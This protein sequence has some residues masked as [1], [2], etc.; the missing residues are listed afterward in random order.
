MHTNKKGQGETIKW[1]RN[2]A[3][4]PDP[5]CL[6]WPFYRN[7]NGYGQMGHNGESHWAHR[8]MCEL[9]HGSAPSPDHEAAHRCGSGHL[10]CVNPRHLAWR[11]KAENRQESTLHGRGHRNPH[12]NK[13]RLTPKEVAEILS[14]KGKERQV[15]IA[16]RFG[17]SW[18][19]VSMIQR[20]KMYGAD[21]KVKHW[22][23][24]EDAKIREAVTLGYSFPQ[25]AGHVGRSVSA[26][27]GRTYRLGLTSGKAP[28]R[29]R[30]A[31]TR[32]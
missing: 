22:T 3:A 10:G 25:M 4:H 9:A 12:G 5:K 19:S 7:P 14:L 26:V 29:D 21:S 32:S 1:L 13:G 30:S 18:Q 23:E 17:I 6:I 8:Y 31:Y 20:G 28:T 27:M 2:H 11:T 15:D 24:V 16:A